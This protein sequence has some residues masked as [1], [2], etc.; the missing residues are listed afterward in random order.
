MIEVILDGLRLLKC[1]KYHL[2]RKVMN[3]GGSQYGQRPI[4]DSYI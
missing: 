3:Y 2:K 1:V 4:L